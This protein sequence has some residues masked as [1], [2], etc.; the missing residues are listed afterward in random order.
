M[1]WTSLQKKLSEQY[2][3]TYF[4]ELKIDLAQY[5]DKHHAYRVPLTDGITQLCFSINHFSSSGYHSYHYPI[6]LQQG[7]SINS[8]TDVDQLVSLLCDALTTISHPSATQQLLGSIRNSLAQSTYF[9]EARRS[10]VHMGTIA[11]DFIAAEQGLLLGH[12]F[13]VTSKAMQGFNDADLR[14]YSPELG[15]AFKLHYFAVTPTLMLERP[16]QGSEIPQDSSAVTAAN[17]LLVSAFQH[18]TLLPCHP[19]QANYLLDKPELQPYLRDESIL[20]LGPLGETVWPTSSVRTVFVPNLGLFIKLSLDVRITNFIRNNPPSHL[21]RAMDTSDYLCQHQLCDAIPGL[22]VL[23]ELGAHSLAITGLEASFAVLYRQGLTPAQTRNTRVVASLVEECPLTGQLP[24]AEFICEAA[25]DHGTTPN[26][27]FVCSWWRAYVYASLLP[28]LQLFAKSGVSLEAHLQNSLML[29]TNGWPTTLVVR[30]MEG[31]SIAPRAEFALAP[32]S[33]ARYTESQAWFRFQYYVLVNHVAHVL[34]AIAR[35]FPVRETQLWQV[36]AEILRDKHLAMALQP[37]CQQL[38]Q[39]THLP[40]K[41]NLL[42]TLKGCG[43]APVWVNIPNPLALINDVYISPSAWQRSESRVLSQLLEALCYEQLLSL[44]W[45]G[46]IAHIRITPTLAYQFKADYT[47][48]FNR[49]RIGPNSLIRLAEHHYQQ[50]SLATLLKDLGQL[51]LTDQHAWL[52]FSDE[53]YQT[54]AKHAQVLAAD[55]HGLLRDLPYVTLEAKVNNGHLYHPSFKSRL[56]FTL[57]DNAQ[58]GP[59]LASPFT[60]QWLAV[61]KS[62]ARFNALAEYADGTLLLQSFTTAQQRELS[63]ELAAQGLSLDTVYLVPVHPW[64]WQHIGALYFARVPGVYTLKCNGPHYL[65]QQS[66]RTLSHADRPQSL[67]V[68]LALSITNT[69]TS[70]V[71]AP[72]TV[73]NASAISD[74]LSLCVADN[75]AWQQVRKPLLLREVAGLSIAGQNSLP[76]EYGA[77]ACIWRESIE[78]KISTMQRAVPVTSLTQLDNDGQPLIAPWIAKHGLSHWLLQ[79][80]DVA[81]IPVMHLLWH[82]GLAMESHAQN[83][84]LVLENDLPVQVALKDFHDGVRYNPAWLANPDLLPQLTDAPAA[85]AAVNPNSFLVT[86]EA[87]ELRDFTQDALCFVNLGELGWFIEQHFGLSGEAFW[88][89][90]AKR[91]MHYQTKHPELKARFALFD[92]FAPQIAVEQLASRRFLPEQRLRVMAVDNPLYIAQQQMAFNMTKNSRNEVTR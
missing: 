40:A 83:M 81:F 72:H 1:I 77:L 43:E 35:H 54:T 4:R 80:I 44:D 76:A 51:Q 57:A 70:R 2:L 92:F 45:H 34:S 78:S 9:T 26:A 65:P 37:Y 8:I 28:A 18:Y 89:S 49:L 71:L 16:L 19:W 60:L 22:L 36:C 33:H 15:A 58:F 85:H 79:L 11:G 53:L 25:A 6:Q 27:E 61:S 62:Q 21:A 13:H 68:K 30:D 59:E 90:V 66:I 67:S 5:G 42:S 14:R 64:Q 23:P 75:F 73:A 87:D 56:G 7:A 52:R 32:D 88:Q 3:N 47:A 41:G 46:G 17:A 39:A 31:A 24:L 38:L 74:W 55:A 63:R 20:S 29:F 82:H 91:V 84:V 48:H 69:S 86:T 50:P 12:P 10:L